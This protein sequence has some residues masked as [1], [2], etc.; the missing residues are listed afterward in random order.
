MVPASVDSSP[1]PAPFKPGQ[2]VR[3]LIDKKE[4]GP[5]YL[6]QISGGKA[7]LQGAKQIEVPVADLRP[8]G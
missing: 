7:T 4:A 6:V 2:N 3:A 8:L 5:F 1:E